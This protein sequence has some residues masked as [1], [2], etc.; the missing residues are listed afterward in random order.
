[1]SLIMISVVNILVYS[2]ILYALDERETEREF[3]QS[4]STGSA[5]QSEHATRLRMLGL[6]ETG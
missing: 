2:Y 6:V 4:E 1:M 3:S 5:I